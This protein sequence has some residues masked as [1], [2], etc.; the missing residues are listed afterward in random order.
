MCLQIKFA[1]AYPDGELGA[2]QEDIA[3]L[4]TLL[5]YPALEC[6]LKVSLRPRRSLLAINSV[7]QATGSERS[8]WW[9]VDKPPRHGVAT[10]G[11]VNTVRVTDLPGPD[12]EK[13][14]YV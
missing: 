11:L 8:P 3:R 5:L 13:R 2:G 14:K 4:L 1:G 10:G 7:Q 6:P 9:A 12:G